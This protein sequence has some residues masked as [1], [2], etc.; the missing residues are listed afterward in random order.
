MKMETKVI[1]GKYKSEDVIYDSSSG[2]AFTVLYEYAIEN[3]YTVYGVKFDKDFKV[4]HSRATTIEEC[5]EFRKSKYVLS[6][7]KSIYQQVEQ[8][9]KGNK[10]VL[11][12]GTPCQCAAISNYMKLRRANMEKLL[13]VDL[14]CHGAPSQKIFDAYRIEN[15]KQMN[16]DWFRFRFRFKGKYSQNGVINSRSAELYYKSGRF[17]YRTAENDPFL[18]G[19]YRRL[20]YRKS[21]AECPFANPERVS[22]ITIGDAWGIEKS[23]PEW[24]SVEGVSLI[25]LN[26]KKGKLLLPEFEKKMT[27]IESSIEWAVSNNS[28]L[29]KPTEMHT[30]RN[31][32]FKLLPNIGFQKAVEK[33]V[34][35]PLWRRG[36]R[37]LKKITKKVLRRM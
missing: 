6:D 9:L 31:V 23:K 1:I 19:Y 25:L 35:A 15:Q 24:N 10:N 4:K 13:L 8:D 2:G 27:V 29:G 17:S 14:I 18:K 12:T 21:C 32:F 11:F 16:D 22:D 36:I 5:E 20:F 33:A 30:N 3:N 34:D 26:S 7:M 37:K 28:Q